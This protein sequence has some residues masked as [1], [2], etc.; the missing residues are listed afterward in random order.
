[1][2]VGGSESFWAP[3]LAGRA[4]GRE[5][6]SL[7]ALGAS[8]NHLRREIERMRVLRNLLHWRLLIAVTLVLGAALGDRVPV[9]AVSGAVMSSATPSN[10]APEAGQQIV[11]SIDIDVSGANPPDHRL[12]SFTGFLDWNTDVLQYNS[13]SG[14]L[15]GFAGLVNPMPGHLIFNGA[16]ATGVTGSNTV[17]TITFDVVGNGVSALNLGYTTMAAASTFA[18]L[19]P[20]LTVN[21]G[22]VVVGTAVYLPMVIRSR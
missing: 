3:Q 19:L 8:P 22:Q 2:P 1:M 18:S 17:L 5:N 9:L 6:A 4:I 14:I 10:A 7:P 11:V 16:N 21:D 12:G 20:V 15:T 13:N